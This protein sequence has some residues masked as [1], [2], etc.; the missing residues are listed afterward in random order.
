MKENCRVHT[1][2]SIGPTAL[3][4]EYTPV[5]S[6]SVVQKSEW[7]R[8]SGKAV[9]LLIAETIAISLGENLTWSRWDQGPS[10]KSKTCL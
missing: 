7:L 1:A 9:A 8:I 3:S 5:I 6:Q 4:I 2:G 10:S